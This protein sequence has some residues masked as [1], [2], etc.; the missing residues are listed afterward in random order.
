MRTGIF[1]I[2]LQICLIFAGTGEG[3]IMKKLKLPGYV[4][5]AHIHAKPRIGFAH[6]SSSP[7]GSP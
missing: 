3:G 5:A 7:K 6:F 2:S 1:A 4:S